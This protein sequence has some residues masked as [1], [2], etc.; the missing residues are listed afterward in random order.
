MSEM[1]FFIQ[2]ISLHPSHAVQPELDP[3]SSGRLILKCMG[4]H[5]R[6]LGR[7]TTFVLV[8]VCRSRQPAPPLNGGTEGVRWSSRSMG[9]ARPS[10]GAA[11][12]VVVVTPAL[13]PPHFGTA[14]DEWGSAGERGVSE[15]LLAALWGCSRDRWQHKLSGGGIIRDTSRVRGQQLASC[16]PLSLSPP[17]Y[18]NENN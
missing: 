4:Q 10:S 13:R 11:A 5:V 1:C 2:A 3:V 17:Q 15:G 16:P 9:S 8:H 18:F 12:R 7:H 6:I 14:A